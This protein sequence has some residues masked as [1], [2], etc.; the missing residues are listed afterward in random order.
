MREMQIYMF[1]KILRFPAFQTPQNEKNADLDVSEDFK[2]LNFWD[3][4][5]RQ[6]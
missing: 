1:Q 6:I 2:M 3:P 4:P 5:K